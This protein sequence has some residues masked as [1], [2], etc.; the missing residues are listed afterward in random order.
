MIRRA[1]ATDLKAILDL[2]LEMSLLHEK[3]DSYFKLR[4]DAFF[5]YE[6]YA[7]DFVSNK[8]KLSIV[9]EEDGIVGYLFAEKRLR[10]PV[11]DDEITGNI[12]DIS[13]SEKHRRQGIGREL[14]RYA[15]NWF[16][17]QDVKKIEL[18]AAVNNPVSMNFWKKAGYLQSTV[19]FLKKL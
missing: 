5:I 6:E 11:Y 8:E 9:C 1:E 14:L 13:V 12:C 7:V 15:E 3:Y 4:E 10:S 18:T 2:W 16:Y 19:K 17:F